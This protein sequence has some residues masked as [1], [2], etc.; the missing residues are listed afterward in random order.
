MDELEKERKLAQLLQATKYDDKSS[1]NLYRHPAMLLSQFWHR[2]DNDATADW[3]DDHSVRDENTFIAHAR[4][5]GPARE[6]AAL[7]PYRDPGRSGVS[8]LVR[9]AN[10]VVLYCRLMELGIIT[11]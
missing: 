5:M 4:R 6:K 10:S 3:F 2:S 9:V 8:D 1:R 11:P 7:E